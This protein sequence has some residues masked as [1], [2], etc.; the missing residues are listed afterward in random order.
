MR[1]FILFLIA[2][3]ATAAAHAAP[4]DITGQWRGKYVCGQG[5]TSLELS[6]GVTASGSLAAT[7]TFGPLPE[8]PT[9]PRG[10]YA[11]TG[12]WQASKR[13]ALLRGVKWMKLPDG[14]MMVDLHGKVDQGGDR[15]SGII[16][17]T[18]CSWFELWRVEPLIG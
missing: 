4:P 6:V 2:I 11:M 18:G 9:V 7:F 1:T 14:Y 13:E 15:Y 5:I 8:N 16:P 10:S 3:A 12:V 17:F